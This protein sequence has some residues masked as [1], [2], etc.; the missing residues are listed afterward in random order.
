MRSLSLLTVIVVAGA[1]QGCNKGDGE[2]RSLAIILPFDQSELD[3]MEDDTNP[4]IE[5]LNYD[6]I[7]DADGF[8]EG[9]VV[10]LAAGERT[11]EVEFDRSPVVFSDF[12]LGTEEGEVTLV[13]SSGRVISGV[14]TVTLVG[15]APPCPEVQVTQPTDG[16]LLEDGDDRDPDTSGFQYDVMASSSAG[17]GQTAE[18]FIDDSPTGDDVAVSSTGL[19]VFQG[20]TLPEGTHTYRIEIVDANES[21]EWDEV[22][23][24][25]DTSAPLCNIIDPGRGVD[26]LNIEEDGDPDRVGMQRDFEVETDDGMAI[27]VSLS[28]DGAESGEENVEDGTATF[29]GVALAE[30]ERNVAA[31]CSDEAGN[32]SRSAPRSFLVD[33]LPPDLRITSP[34]DGAYITTEDD[35]YPDMENIQFEVIVTSASDDVEGQETAAFLEGASPMPDGGTDLM[36]GGDVTLYVEASTAGEWN[37]IAEIEDVAGNPASASI[38]ILVDI[39]GAQVQIVDPVGGAVLNMASD[40]DGGAPGLQYDVIACASE[41]GTA[42]LLNDGPMGVAAVVTEAPCETPTGVLDYTVT[43]AGVTLPEGSQVLNVEF[44]DLADIL[45]TSPDVAILVDTVPPECSLFAPVC[46]STL[47][48]LEMPLSILTLRANYESTLHV[49]HPDAGEYLTLTGPSG[50]GGFISFRDVTLLVGTSSFSCEATDENGNELITDPA[51]C[52]VEVRSDH[53]IDITTPA[54]GTLFGSPDDRD[55]GAGYAIQVCA[56]SVTV[57]EGTLGHFEVDAVEGATSAFTGGTACADVPVVEGDHT[58]R[59]WVDVDGSLAEDSVAVTI[60]L[61]PTGPV[62]GLTAEVLDRRESSL[63]LVW[64]TPG[65]RVGS[66]EVRWSHDPIETEEDFLAAHVARWEAGSSGPGTLVAFDINDLT[67][68]RDYYV[69]VRPID[70]AGNPGLFVATPDSQRPAFLTQLTTVAAAGSSMGTLLSVAGNLDGEDGDDL[71]VAATNAAYIFFSPMPGTPTWA[72]DTTITVPGGWASAVGVDDFNG[73]GNPDLAV[74]APFA[75]SNAGALYVFFGGPDRTWGRTLDAA[76]A[77]VT[78]TGTAAAGRMGWTVTGAGDFC[79]GA[80]G[81][82]GFMDIAVSAPY[83]SANQGYS[84]VICGG[85]IEPGLVTTVDAGDLTVLQITGAD[86]GV[87]APSF[88]VGVAGLGDID[89]DDYDDLALGHFRNGA[90]RV[91]V[92]RG[93]SDVTIAAESPILTSDGTRVQTLVGEAADDLFGIRVA[94]A[95]DIDQDGFADLVV[96]APQNDEAGSNAGKVYI[97][98]STGDWLDPT[99]ASLVPDWATP[100]DDL[101]GYM[102]AARGAGFAGAPDRSIGHTGVPGDVGDVLVIANI[103]HDSGGMRLS[104]RVACIFGGPGVVDAGDELSTSLLVDDPATV[105]SQDGLGFVRAVGTEAFSLHHTIAFVGDIDGDGYEDFATADQRLPES[106]WSGQVM[107]YY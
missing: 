12:T 48:S 76:A 40:R 106:T 79:G 99:F 1:L 20:V 7:I 11:A 22:E 9:D 38:S 54:P 21:C 64:T 69:A 58:I 3:F 67:I 98:L 90:G 18:L 34:S 32:S 63:R 97:Y 94:G 49:T 39:E 47:S 31:E 50:A 10:T 105:E 28:V 41:D 26:V 23:V 65:E 80:A 77:D 71:V 93:M 57:P 87:R 85:D 84:Y 52:Q 43:F 86:V 66:H 13:A 103:G 19:I 8:T 45:A 81:G 36:A 16:A 35:Y 17:E 59:V 14:V 75:N 15:L 25:V 95:G 2:T 27:T 92:V 24:T 37:V 96:G 33:T 91:Y 44:R 101:F 30:G 55:P 5:G 102:I 104:G 70:E 83:A 62:T 107:V 46:G 88:S 72:P 29:E 61:T 73:D 56:G 53:V 100:A 42:E 6:V 4:E 78:V 68:E 60:D 82:D 89:G 51:A 74:G